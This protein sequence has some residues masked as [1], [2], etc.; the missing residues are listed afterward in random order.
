[1][2]ETSKRIKEVRQKRYDKKMSQVEF[3]EKIGVSR[4]VISNIEYGRVEPS[5]IVIRSIVRE[6]GVNEL[7]LRTGKGDMLA[8]VA[9]E[10]QIA[11]FIGGLLASGS[12][13][14]KK[15]FAAAMA[16]LPDEAWPL[17]EAF[18]RKVLEEPDE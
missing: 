16:N 13:S 14:F 10:E 7:W 15:R 8:P 6:F 2:S 18:C 1:M 9:K 3:G 4:D 17:V 12:E 11:D 5:E